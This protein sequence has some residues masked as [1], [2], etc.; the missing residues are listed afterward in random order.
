MPN[1]VQRSAFVTALSPLTVGFRRTERQIVAAATGL[2][3]Q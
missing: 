1:A 2:H 3:D